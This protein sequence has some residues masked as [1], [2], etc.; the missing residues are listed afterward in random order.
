MN[1]TSTQHNSTSSAP[2][3]GVSSA[4]NGSISIG[5]SAGSNACCNSQ[6][7]QDLSQW[8]SITEETLFLHDGLLRLSDIVELPQDVNNVRDSGEHEVVTLDTKTPA[9]L[10]EHIMSVCGTQNN[11]YSRLLEYRLNALCG[12]WNA[13]RQVAASIYDQQ[14]ERES[15]DD[16]AIWK[17]QGSIKDIEQASFSTRI[18]LLLVLPLLESM[19]RNDPELCSVSASVLLECLKDCP[20]F[21]LSKEPADCMKGLEQLLCNWLEEKSSQSTQRSFLNSSP[22]QQKRPENSDTLQVATCSMSAISKQCERVNAA[23]ALVALACA[24]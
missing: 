24:R 8:L 19:S 20:P 15:S 7:Q 14:T 18:S 13:Q 16:T 4:G 22:H 17:K 6:E 1:N 9:E 21:S 5:I 2:N 10:S 3:S 12:F 11:A 23:S